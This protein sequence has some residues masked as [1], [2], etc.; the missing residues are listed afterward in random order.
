VPSI[1]AAAAEEAGA[2]EAIGTI[3]VLAVWSVADAGGAIV[4]GEYKCM[5]PRRPPIVDS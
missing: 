2:L 4:S 3:I 1:N 5:D